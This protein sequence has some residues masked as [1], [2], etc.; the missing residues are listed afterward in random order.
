MIKDFI[1]KID[2]NLKNIIT[3]FAGVFIIWG[4]I[5]LTSSPIKNSANKDM[6][7]TI[8]AFGNLP[9]LN[10]AMQENSILKNSVKELMSYDTDYLFINYKQVNDLIVN[11]MFL[12]IGLTPEQ[13]KSGNMQGLADYFIRRVYNLSKDTPIKNNPILE[14]Y[15]WAGLFQKFK[16]KLLMQGQGRKIYDGVAYYNSERDFMVVE[17]GL[18]KPFLD[19]LVQYIQTQPKDKQADFMNNYLMFVNEGLGLKNL[20]NEELEWLKSYGFIKS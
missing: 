18:S 8:P 12:W 13:I 10:L 5:H 17:G 15:P 1:K 19:R 4:I 3:V 16:A 20:N 2:F 7:L 11:I 6:I 9:D 14:K